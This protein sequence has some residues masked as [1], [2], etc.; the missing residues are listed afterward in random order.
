[1]KSSARDIT[2]ALAAIVLEG[3]GAGNDPPPDG[4]RASELND[5]T[6]LIEFKTD[7]DPPIAGK[8]V[9]EVR[10]R[11]RSGAPLKD[12]AVT[13]LFHMP[14]TPSMNMPEMSSRSRLEPVW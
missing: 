14:A 12:E 13:V 2:A 11:R 7:P 1:M 6:M 5:P 4:G 8:N 3:C 9:F 10:L